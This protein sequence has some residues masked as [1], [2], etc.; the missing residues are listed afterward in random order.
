MDICFYSTIAQNTSVN[1]NIRMTW[2]FDWDVII[3]IT[4][5][6]LVIGLICQDYLITSIQY[7]WGNI[8]FIEVKVKIT[9][10]FDNACF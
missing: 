7:C 2:N 10:I 6:M 3:D 1:Q 8:S 4:D 5:Y 9:I